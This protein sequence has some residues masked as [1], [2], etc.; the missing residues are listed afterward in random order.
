MVL[1]NFM[2]RLLLILLLLISNLLFLVLFSCSNSGSRNP[3]ETVIRL[4]GA[5]ER[6]EKAAILNLVDIPA[7]MEIS[8]EDY[9]L[10]SDNPRTFHNPED[11]LND[12]TG[13]GLTKRRWFSM[14]RVI[15]KMEI[16][17]DTAFVEVSFI[18]K[19]KSKQYYNKFGLHRKDNNWKI[20][21]FRTIS[22]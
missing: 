4:F 3:K 6:D 15:G 14:Q 7:L 5:M 20:Y 8:G 13:D 18:D 10:Q 19:D 2:R 16:V 11:I 21:N 1:I 12:L 17:G 9:A 22:Q